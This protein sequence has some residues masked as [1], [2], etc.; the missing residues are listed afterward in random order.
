MFR[1]TANSDQRCEK[2]SILNH[3]WAD[4]EA[5]IVMIWFVVRE[6]PRVIHKV[7]FP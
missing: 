7:C 4:E 6:S 1:G 5:I 2:S 3:R